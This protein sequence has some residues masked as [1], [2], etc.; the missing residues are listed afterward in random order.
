MIGATVRSR[1]EHHCALATGQPTST[2]ELTEATE[3]SQCSGSVRSV[4][5][6]KLRQYPV[7]VNGL[8]A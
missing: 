6:G 5:I 7:R 3:K 4:V 1:A 8:H 2:T